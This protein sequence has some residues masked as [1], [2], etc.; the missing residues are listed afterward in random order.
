MIVI[1]SALAG[2]VLGGVR[3]KRRQGTRADVAQYAAAHAIAFALVGLV[4]T[5]ALERL[6]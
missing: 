1:V 4:L 3:A 2:V 6:V 5:I